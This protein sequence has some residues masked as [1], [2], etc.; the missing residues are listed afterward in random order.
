MAVARRNPLDGRQ[1]MFAWAIA[2]A[3]GVLAAMAGVSPTGSTVIDVV[4]VAGAAGVVTWSSATAPWWAVAGA[5]SVAALAAAGPIALGIALLGWAGI[6]FVGIRRRNLPWVRCL[7]A[8]TAVQVLARQNVGG[9]LGLSTL[10][11]LGALGPLF[12]LAVLRRHRSV[13]N[14]VR[15]VLGVVVVFVGLA[16]AGLAVA[17][18]SA[19]APLREGNNQARVG[20][21]AL[22][23]GDMAAAATAFGA[24]ADAFRRADDDLSALWGQPSRLVP[25][26]AQHRASGVTVA[27]SAARAMTQATQA[28]D[29]IDPSTL[30]VT[31]GRIDLDAVRAL[32]APFIT[33]QTA[34]GDLD[35]A[36]A[37]AKSQWLVAPLQNK[38]NTLSHDLKKNKVRADNAVLAVQLAPAMLGGEGPRHY[39]VAF[40]TPAEARGLGG[41]MGN[42]AEITIDNGT[43]EMTRFGRHTDLS[44][45]GP[46]PLNRRLSGPAEF[47][48]RWGRFGFYDPADGTTDA[49]PWSNITM[50]PDFAMVGDV[51]SQLYPQSGGRTLDG[52]FS[53]DPEAIAALVSFTGPIKVDGVAKPLTAANTA[54]FIIRDQYLVTQTAARVD[55]LDEVAHTVVDKLLSGSLPPPADLA[56]TLGPLTQQ[57]RLMGWSAHPD[58]EKLFT[59]IG[60]SGAFPTLDGGNGVA[61]V[62][63]NA[64]G[65]K[66]DAY[67][68]MSTTYRAA[69][70]DAFGQTAGTVTVTLKNNAPPSG[71]PLEV[72]GS[73]PSLSLPKGSNRMFL[74][75]Y[76]GLPMVGVSLDGVPSTMETDTSLGWNVAATFLNIGPG[77]TRVLTMQ[78]R[79][80]LKDPSHPF[81]TRTQ[82]MVKP[83]PV[84]VSGVAR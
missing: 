22:N 5:C 44:A 28:L 48:K 12:V 37:D 13:R 50:P 56:K 66:V 83:S 55:L 69:P 39:F 52:A 61:V 57:N 26:L 29:Q 49:V 59:K 40:T 71:L 7:S 8:L 3:S 42:F 75:I 16:C 21:S 70:V 65:N 73:A 1:P 25:V 30:R 77:E 45:G 19:R 33:L 53:M 68:D 80:T 81:V 6:F 20:L 24:A 17:A 31:K 82:P 74:S 23:R 38:L 43:L 62:I 64:A 34:I 14:R 15:T 78:V 79:G 35:R 67:L 36:L 84:V 47:I 54:N 10:I 4:L 51:I 27:S 63:D 46:D 2:V 9:F 72:I 32:V 58:E 11:A 60:M 76:T 41:F 18:L